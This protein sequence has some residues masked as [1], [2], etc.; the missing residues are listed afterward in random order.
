MS[1][2][3]SVGFNT[4]M[5]IQNLGHRLELLDQLKLREL[6]VI[7]EAYHQECERYRTLAKK[8]WS[9]P[10]TAKPIGLLLTEDE[11][12]KIAARFFPGLTYAIYRGMLDEDAKALLAND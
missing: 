4:G 12:D 5:A 7:E 11:V 1:I 9:P 2:R 8:N 6:P 10:T 3:K